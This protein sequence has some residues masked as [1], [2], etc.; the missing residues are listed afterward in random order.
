MKRA[1]ESQDKDV[2]IIASGD[3]SHRLKADG[4]YGY[5]PSGPE[6]DKTITTLIA[7]GDVEEYFP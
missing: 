7:K 3:L 1:I 5:H 2:V 4:P 6:L